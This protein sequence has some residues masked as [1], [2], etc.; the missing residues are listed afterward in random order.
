[1]V[2]LISP[3]TNRSLKSW[4]AKVLA[5]SQIQVSLMNT[6]THISTRMQCNPERATC[7]NDSIAI[8]DKSKETL[9]YVIQTI[10]LV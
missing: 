8:L 6:Y 2:E 4:R 10:N 9:L 5:W 7:V 3:A 1:M